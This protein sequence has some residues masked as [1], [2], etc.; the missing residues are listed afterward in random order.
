MTKKKLNMD[1]QTILILILVGVGAGM[2]GG[3]PGTERAV[4]IHPGV[5]AARERE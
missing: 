5:A 2:L 3:L 1:V 4:G